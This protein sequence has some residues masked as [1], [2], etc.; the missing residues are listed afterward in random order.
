MRLRWLV[1]PRILCVF[2]LILVAGSVVGCKEV[3]ARRDIQEAN[4]LYYATKYEEA[5]KLYD[6]ALVAS[7]QL[8]IGWYNLGLAHLAL[9]SPGSKD[10]ANDSHAKGAIVAFE[11]YLTL[12]PLDTDVSDKLIGTYIASG[13]WDGAIDFFAKKLEKNPNDVQAVSQLAQINTLAGRF[14]EAIRWHKKKAD[15][16]T[17]PA[18]KADSWYTIGVVDWRRLNN[19]ADVTGLDRA[20]IA[21]EGLA[22]LQQAD[23]IRPDHAPT[24]S[25]LN[26]LYRERASSSDVSYAR[27]VDT[28][29]AQVY[30]KRAVELVNKKK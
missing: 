3:G 9:F 1:P 11:K 14:D 20:R 19:H 23:A 16:A 30:Y 10:P 2:S 17:D 5:I 24:L 7:P 15:M 29:S 12:D 25:Y 21:D 6:D 8:A 27:V 18:A 28:A 22:W 26:L 4:K 13:R